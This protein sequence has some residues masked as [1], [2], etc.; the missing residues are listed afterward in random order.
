MTWFQRLANA[1]DEALVGGR[2]LGDRIELWALAAGLAVVVIVVLQTV[3][4]VSRRRLERLP[5][6]STRRLLLSVAGAMR[7]LPS[8]IL[9]IGIG[10]AVLALPSAWSTAGRGAVVIGTGL[11]LG[12]MASQLLSSL[13]Q[14]ESARRSAREQ[15]GGAALAMF[16]LLGQTAVWSVA[17]LL[18]LTNLGIDVTG[19]VASLG[20]GGIAVA[21]AAQNV[22]GDLFASLSIVLDR[23]FETGDFINSGTE[24]GTVKKIGIKSTRIQSL[25]GEEIVVGNAALL[26]S[27]IRNFKKMRERRVLVRFGVL[28]SSETERLREVPK[29]CQEAV[30]CQAPKA[31]F[32]RAHLDIFAPSA[33]EFELVYFVS[34]GN[35]TEHMDV[36]QAILLDIFD[37]LK[38]LGLQLAL[39]TSTVHL[40]SVPSGWSGA[41]PSGH[42][43]SVAAQ[44]SSAPT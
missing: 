2:I 4:V 7:F 22:L 12:L 36:K 31:R 33:L 24:M 34:S 14:R 32:D 15:L 21:L 20:V 42:G 37:G 38:G 43:A 13:V 23:P 35:F 40:A 39:P 6:T 11:Q 9:G 17:L 25:S 41:P 3:A 19:L 29:L 27:R 8:L 16:Q 10:S 28:Y 5:E 44:D 30:A 18:V 1:V 26:Q